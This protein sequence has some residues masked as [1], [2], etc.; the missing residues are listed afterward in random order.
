MKDRHLKRRDKLRRAVRNTDADGL[1]VTSYTNVTYLTGFTG[2]D[3]FLLVRRDGDL[4]VTDPRYTTQLGEECP[5]LDLHV[6]RPGTTMPEAVT[7]VLRR[8]KIGRLGIEAE[9]MTVSLRDQIADKL[10]KLEILPTTGLVEELRQVKDKHEVSQIRRAVWL[11]EKAFGVLRASLR[12]DKTEKEVAD[13]L[14][15][16]LRLF[17]AT[18]SGFPTIVAVG[19][20]AA[21]PHATP[22]HGRI[23]SGDLLL[24]DWGAEEGFYKS[25][26]TR[27]LVTGRISPKLER[28]YRVVFTAQRKAIAA[29]RPGAVAHDVDRAAREVIS[30]AGFGRYFGHG[31]GHGIGLEVHE[32][33]RLAANSRVV[34]K[35]GM[36]MTVEPGIY[37]PGWGGVR[38]EDDVLVTRTGHEVLTKVPREWEAA[39]VR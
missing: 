4:I 13:E 23:G 27:V 22:G 9:S 11:A 34:L 25:D 10:P 5:G 35:P 7:K 30:Q 31:L 17:G 29:V 36:V 12:P 16:Q 1:L 39:V 15:Y 19:P 14:E 3:S 28:I 21:L 32:A 38:I 18:R 6:R 8:A 33:P 20:R 24:I 37:L 2:D 26:L